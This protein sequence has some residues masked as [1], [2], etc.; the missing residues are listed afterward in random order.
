MRLKRLGNGY[1]LNASARDTEEWATRL[2]DVWPC[3]T[4][5]GHRLWVDVD[6]NGLVDFTIDGKG[7][8]WIDGH[9]LEAFVSDA[10]QGT[11]C[12]EFW[13]LWGQKGDPA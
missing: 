12:A 8:G 6:E 9:E 4:L 5:R 13:P 7:P 2:G 11:N 1:A 3:S 10:I